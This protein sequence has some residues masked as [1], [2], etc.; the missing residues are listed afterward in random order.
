MSVSS[1]DDED[2][3]SSEAHWTEFESRGDLVRSL[4]PGFKSAVANFKRL[5]ESARS[6]KSALSDLKRAVK[7]AHEFAHEA[8]VVYCSGVE[9][10]EAEGQLT[11]GVQDGL[12]LTD[13]FSVDF[14]SQVLDEF[15]NAS[16]DLQRELEKLLEARQNL[17]LELERKVQAE[18]GERLRRLRQEKADSGMAAAAAAAAEHLASSEATGA[19]GGQGGG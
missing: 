12:G 7:G 3:S 8:V 4:V 18:L 19:G 11:R 16:T 10:E 13:V 14:V 9:A 6:F 2:T 17:T 15:K 1:D 5:T